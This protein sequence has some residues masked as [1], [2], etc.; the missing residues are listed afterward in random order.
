MEC[1]FVMLEYALFL[2][3]QFPGGD[4]VI[5]CGFGRSYEQVFSNPLIILGHNQNPKVAIIYPYNGDLYQ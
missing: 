5:V 2:S 1:F 3:S 4:G